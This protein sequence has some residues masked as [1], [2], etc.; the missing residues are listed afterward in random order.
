MSAFAEQDIYG[1]LFDVIGA[2]FWPVD[3]VAAL[4]L[5]KIPSERPSMAK[6]VVLKIPFPSA[7]ALYTWVIV[8]IDIVE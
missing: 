5:Q 7:Y 3:K 1:E 4:Y 8:H 2:T 6:L